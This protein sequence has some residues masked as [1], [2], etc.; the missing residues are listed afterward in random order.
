MPD[1]YPLTLRQADQAR[2]DF[3]VIE[4]HLESI[5]RSVPVLAAHPDPDGDPRQ[6]PAA[7][8]A[9]AAAAAAVV[10]AAAREGE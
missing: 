1:E 2:T 9:R 8:G 10:C 6:A 5:A 3:A 7:A 4:E